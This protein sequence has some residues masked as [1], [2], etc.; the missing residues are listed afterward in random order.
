MDEFPENPPGVMSVVVEDPV[1][2]VAALASMVPAADAP[3]IAP[4]NVPVVPD[5]APEKVPVV[6]LTA[7][8][9][10]PVVPDTAPEKVP[11][12]PKTPDD[13]VND[14]VANV[15]PLAGVIVMLPDVSAAIMP[16]CVAAV[17]SVNCIYA[18]PAP[19]V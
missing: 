16:R 15:A 8:V 6:P 4:E 7:P 12:V 10:V 19:E 13:A 17:L 14:P 1:S 5:T 3:D 11:V 9:K 18:G 2:V